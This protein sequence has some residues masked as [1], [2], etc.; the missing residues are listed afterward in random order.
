MPFIV[1]I[2]SLNFKTCDKKCR[3]SAFLSYMLPFTA[4]VLASLRDTAF[5][6]VVG[7]KKLSS[8]LSKPQYIH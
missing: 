2:G 7:G 1:I 4:I 8:I 5:V 6:N 3:V